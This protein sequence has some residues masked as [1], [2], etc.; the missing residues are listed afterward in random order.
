M[1]P[2]K[3]V[4]LGAIA[5]MVQIASVASAQRTPARARS[6]AV[7][8]RSFWELGFDSG[9]SF[10][11]TT[12]RVTTLSIPAASFR[13][14]Y[15]TSEVLSI[16]PFFGLNHVSAQGGGSFTTYQLGVGGLYHFSPERTRRQ[17]YVRPFL[18]FVGV[19]TSGGGGSNS[20]IGV[21][22]G[23]G[24]KW[25]K[26]GGRMALRGEGNIETINSNTL[27][28]FLFGFSFFTR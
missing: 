8:H 19:S 27:L 12:P 10:G 5:L 6:A 17:V 3:R 26:L 16:E 7:Q 22:V 4:V 20:D 15:W 1:R 28:N 2:I 14:G 21:G 9:L 13:A 11:F 25:P 18:T 24:L 23:A